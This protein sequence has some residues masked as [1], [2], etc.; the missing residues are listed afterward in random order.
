MGYGHKVEQHKTSS[1]SS[2]SSSTSVLSEALLFATMCIIGLPVDALLKDGSVYSGIFHT[3]SVHHQYGIV[4]KKARMTKKGKSNA[5]VINGRV[6]ET[7]VILSDDLVQVL[8]KGVSIPTNH[9]TGNIAV[10][11]GEAAVP[12]K[13]LVGGEKKLNKFNVEQKK[14]TQK[15]Q[16]NGFSHGFTSQ[17]VGKENG[18]T[19]KSGVDVEHVTI[20]RI[21][22]SKTEKVPEVS[23]NERQV[24]ADRLIGEH[25]N[26]KPK[27][28]CQLKERVDDENGS[29]VND[30]PYLTN[31]MKEK[32]ERMDFKLPNGV[33][34]DPSPN[35]V[36]SGVSTTHDSNLNAPQSCAEPNKISKEFKLNP[37]AKI[38]SPSFANPI[39]V[40]APMMPSVT[41]MAY[42]QSNSP[43]VGL[44]EVGI[45][46]LVSC[47]S[48]PP[49][50]VQYGNLT[51]GNGGSASQFSQ[52]NI[53]HMANMTHPARYA[54]QYHP[55]QAGPTY[56]NPNSQAVMIGR[57]GQQ[58][59]YLQPASHDLVHQGAATMPQL[60]VL[61]P[62]VQ[63]PKHQGTPTVLHHMPP[64][65]MCVPQPFM[66]NGQQQFVVPSHVPQ[67]LQHPF[68]TSRPIPV[69]GPN[70]LYG[71]KFP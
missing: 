67:I 15:R 58:F 62:P 49:K 19:A 66:G 40:T 57:V 64:V 44:P 1:S 61:T 10:G 45:N 34:R 8:A 28:D 11:N 30:V 43:M 52:P 37:G 71:T 55:V 53:G 38:F 70:G 2:S 25:D 31:S 29:A 21:N 32:P 14:S 69:P 60:P 16:N 20:V 23:I 54:A 35:A 39:S 50:F 7:L 65:P 27:S 59:V 17:K 36:P 22:K 13:R 6:I 63:F 5:N 56:M 33:S 51:A 41:S 4:L 47:S 26:C 48:A 3:A 9:V 42:V 12:S 46:P 18:G 24:Q 68:P